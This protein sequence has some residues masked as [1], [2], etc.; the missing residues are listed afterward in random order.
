MPFLSRAEVTTL[1]EPARIAFQIEHEHGWIEWPLALAGTGVCFWEWSRF[2]SIFWAIAGTFATA[3]VVANWA[4]GSRTELVVT[5]DQLLARG[6][7]GRLFSSETTIRTADVTAMRYQV[8]GEGAPSGLYVGHG[9]RS[10]CLVPE[11]SEDQ[12]NQILDEIFRRFPNI[13]T[14]DSNPSSLL[15]GPSCDLTKLNLK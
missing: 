13:A 4:R 8:G 12:T 15:F 1:P 5:A 9:W 6:N 14:G 7:I 3:S 11:I 10:T 2:H